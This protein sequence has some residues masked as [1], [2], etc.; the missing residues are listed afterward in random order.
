MKK[1]RV[2]EARVE[3]EAHMKTTV[4]RI[5][6]DYVEK[7]FVPREVLEGDKYLHAMLLRCDASTVDLALAEFKERALE[8][9]TNPVTQ[10]S[11]PLPLF[12]S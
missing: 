7:G 11:T 1:A 8:E 6:D 9:L 4:S 3:Q 5:I 12:D 10:T 2:E